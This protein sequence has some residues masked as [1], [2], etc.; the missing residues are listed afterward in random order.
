MKLRLNGGN[1]GRHGQR[2]ELEAQFG[3]DVKGAMHM[4]RVLGEGIELMKT[5]RI[6]LPRPEV[7]FL[8]DVRNGKYTREEVNTMADELFALLEK[9]T[10][11]SALPDEIDR[12]KIS[13][14]IAA[15][16]LD[17]WG[18]GHGRPL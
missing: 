11:E 14:I 6:T 5:G 7:P 18:L 15:T 1:T 4:L 8:K 2:P 16:Q 10:R 3:Y 12:A 9:S 17:F 13:R